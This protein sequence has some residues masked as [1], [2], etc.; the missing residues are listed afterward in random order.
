VSRSFEELLTKLETAKVAPGAVLRDLDIVD[1]GVRFETG[2]PVTFKYA[3]NTEPTPNMGSRFQQDIEPAGFYVIHQPNPHGTPG[4]QYG[5]CTL[6]NPLVLPFGTGFNETS[7]KAELHRRYKKKGR[8]LSRALRK[9][10]FDGV[11]TT[12]G[13]TKEI[14][15]LDDKSCTVARTV[16][17]VK[18]LKGLPPE[19][20]ELAWDHWFMDN[21]KTIAKLA[22]EGYRW[23]YFGERAPDRIPVA[24][25]IIHMP[26]V[27]TPSLKSPGGVVIA[28]KKVLPMR[29]VLDNNLGTEPGLTDKM[30]LIW[31]TDFYKKNPGPIVL[32]NRHSEWAALV[33]SATRK[34]VKWQGS[35]FDKDGPFG[36]VEAQ[37]KKR[38]IEMLIDD[39]FTIPDPNA[40]K[41][42]VG[43][44]AGV[45]NGLAGKDDDLLASEQQ[46]R[47]RWPA[48]Q[49]AVEEMV[50]DM[51]SGGNPEDQP[52][53]DRLENAIATMHDLGWPG[54][55]QERTR[56]G[57]LS[58]AVKKSMNASAEAAGVIE[59]W[60]SAVDYKDWG[61][62]SIVSKLDGLAD[63]PNACSTLKFNDKEDEIGNFDIEV[64]DASGKIVAELNTERSSNQMIIGMVKVDPGIQRCGVGT[65]LY[66][67]AA[68]RGC[69]K[70]LLLRSDSWRTPASEGFWKKQE[71][72]GRARC[73]VGTGIPG[74]RL[75]PDM[76]FERDPAGKNK[77]WEC[78]WYEMNDACP[79]TLADAGLGGLFGTGITPKM[80]LVAGGVGLGAFLVLKKRASAAP[81]GSPSAF[82]LIPPLEHSVVRSAWGEA[83]TSRGGIH[84]G[85]DLHAA[86]GTPI[87]AL[88]GGSVVKVGT[89]DSDTRGRHVYLRFVIPGIGTFVARHLHLDQV[90]VVKGQTVVRGQQLGTVGRS[91]T[92]K[93]G[94]HLHLDIHACTSVTVSVWINRFGVPK[95][96]FPESGHR[97]GGCVP[98]PVE[99]VL[100]VVG[101]TQSV[102][103]RARERGVVLAMGD[104]VAVG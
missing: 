89:T 49:D 37:S 3:H 25:K 1:Q 100:P 98:V 81:G 42:I 46:R 38:A 75:M 27:S 72:K 22:S 55:E 73:V 2:V 95:G 32:A 62:P 40:M 68:A 10:G 54:I 87:R 92:A 31:I 11:V 82:G 41:R 103:D 5:T 30:A 47:S 61:K 70:G 15:V 43:E 4:W 67:R 14:V 57:R 65:R 56:T 90:N 85:V 59:S 69:N 104:R 86:V 12:N 21:Q 64:T 84:R 33:H 7:W 71:K 26:A 19:A 96:G 102:I 74:K 6:N 13:E 60:M 80:A 34:G 93:S 36:H 94:A 66:E 51:R 99:S 77:L 83:R 88:A 101:Y 35:K 16:K 76:S 8:A 44:L 79:D 24:R 9:E 17:P 53:I 45:S 97:V 48:Y 18:D 52:N 23:V 39:G 78:D 63:A 28:T 91:G 29:T 50:E 58:K 20:T